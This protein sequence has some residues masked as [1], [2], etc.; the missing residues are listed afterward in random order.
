MQIVH[1]IAKA[2]NR[3][4]DPVYTY[5]DQ[6]RINDWLDQQ[7]GR[8]PKGYRQFENFENYKVVNPD[9]TIQEYHDTSKLRKI[10]IKLICV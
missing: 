3:T 5:D 4:T 6:R 1:P 2:A 9:A 10:F 8:Y 7:V